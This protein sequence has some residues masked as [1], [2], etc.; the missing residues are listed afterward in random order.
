MVNHTQALPFEIWINILN[1]IE[2][3]QQLAR[4]RLVCKQW[5]PVAEKAMFSGNF[6]II[7]DDE[8]FVAKL[9]YHLTTKPALALLIKSIDLASSNISQ[10]APLCAELLELVMT[11]NLEKITE[12]FPL[13]HTDLVYRIIIRSAHKF[14]RIKWIPVNVYSYLYKRCVYALKDSLEFIRVSIDEEDS[15]IDLDLFG[16]FK[17]LDWLELVHSSIQDITDLDLILR[18][19][20]CA[21]KLDL[22]TNFTGEDYTSKSGSQME[23]WLI[24]NVR[25]DERI[26]SIVDLSDR[27][28][29]HWC[30][31]I[32]YIVYK[33]PK[34]QF[35][36]LT[37]LA[38]NNDAERV[39]QAIKHI[40]SLTL[41]D[42][43]CNSADHLWAV[44][45]TIKSASNV[46]K[47]K[48]SP[49]VVSG[50][51]KC[52]IEQACRRDRIATS[53][54]SVK[55]QSEAPHAYFERFLSSAGSGVSVITKANIDLVHWRCQD[56][57]K[58]LLSLY[59]ILRLLPAVQD[60]EFGDA[61]IKY[62]ASGNCDLILNDLKKL[63]IVGAKIDHR[64]ITQL[65]I[66]APNLHQLTI[67]SSLVVG[68]E[69]KIA[70]VMPHS[71]LSTLTFQTKDLD[72]E[73]VE[74]DYEQ[75]SELR[76]LRLNGKK[77]GLDKITYLCIKTELFP[78]KRYAL[79]PI[80]RVITT[81]S[82]KEF[83]QQATA[84]KT[85]H[86][87]CK[88]LLSLVFASSNLNITMHFQDGELTS[89]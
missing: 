65:S 85:V 27:S 42:A 1:Q 64:V 45:D 51:G 30:N 26:K 73:T 48:Y 56:N 72:S 28:R 67:S 15:T 8:S 36:Q 7:P 40:P 19:L 9:H 76:E 54:F 16:E 34:L 82:E 50:D 59:D 57:S 84:S 79:E 55:L 62:Q 13:I 29:D 81:L 5:N 88:S 21:T 23:T 61:I 58:G 46:I 37:R 43:E 49:Y 44:G 47:I 12:T 38:L 24:R 20:Q 22:W 77:M 3:P 63:E 2:S 18:Q 11:S 83:K 31:L 68:R 78:E 53:E 25:I 87:E 14:G 35:L 10:S 86:I 89:R 60:F 4:C 41:V 52:Q 32:E 74:E 69:A 71:N 75:R 33:Y 66:S 6:A 70:I 17:R 80:S 39:L